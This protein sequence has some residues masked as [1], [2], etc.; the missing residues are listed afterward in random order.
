MVDAPVRHARAAG[1]AVTVNRGSE[2]QGSDYALWEEFEASAKGPKIYEASIEAIRKRF[3]LMRID[4]A[5]KKTLTDDAIHFWVE[6]SLGKPH[7][8]AADRLVALCTTD[9][10]P[11][12][13]RAYLEELVRGDFDA[14]GRAVAAQF[15]NDKEAVP[16]SLAAG[17]ARLQAQNKENNG[18][19]LSEEE[20]RALQGKPWWISQNGPAQGPRLEP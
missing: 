12:F 11:V 8:L 16:P 17:L 9:P 20:R 7:Q 1:G 4:E 10:L 19:D 6:R 13:R 18:A 15:L 3:G 5:R 14:A 2:D